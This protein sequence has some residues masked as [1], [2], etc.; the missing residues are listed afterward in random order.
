MERLPNAFSLAG[1]LLFFFFP[2]LVLVSRPHY[3]EGRIW[4]LVDENTSLNCS[5]TGDSGSQSPAGLL[6]ATDHKALDGGLVCAAISGH[7]SGRL[8]RVL[9]P[10]MMACYSGRLCRGNLKQSKP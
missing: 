3:Q 6:L 1:G 9:W 4:V 2:W 8:R 10:V 5:T 7:Y